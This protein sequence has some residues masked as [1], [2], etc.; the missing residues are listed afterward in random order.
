M[1]RNDLSWRQDKQDQETG[2]QRK[3][4]ATFARSEQIPVA[5]PGVNRLRTVLPKAL[6]RGV[7]TVGLFR[8]EGSDR[9]E[10]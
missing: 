2:R 4:V 1:A 9:L 7:L 5:E 8:L 3:R 6:F 10:P